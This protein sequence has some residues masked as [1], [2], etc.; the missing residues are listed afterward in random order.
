[1]TMASPCTNSK[2]RVVRLPADG[3][4]KLKRMAIRNRLSVPKQVLWLIENALACENAADQ[5]A[6]APASA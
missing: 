3:H 4:A 2:T 1:M 5:P 6:A